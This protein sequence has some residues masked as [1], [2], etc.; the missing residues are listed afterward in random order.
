VIT[1]RACSAEKN[2]NGLNQVIDE[3]GAAKGNETAGFKGEWG[4]LRKEGKGNPYKE[5]KRRKARTF[6][7]DSRGKE[8]IS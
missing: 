5:R 8:M 4:G 1:T 6:K 3:T 2:G 7:T